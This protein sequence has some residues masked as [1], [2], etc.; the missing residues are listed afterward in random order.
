MQLIPIRE[1]LEDNED[2]IK[3]PLCQETV[4]MTTDFYKKVG[5]VEPWIGYYAEENRDLVGSAGIQVNI[6]QLAYTKKYRIRNLW[7]K[8]DLGIFE[9]NFSISIAAHGAGMFKLVPVE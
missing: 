7:A 5:F 8:K 6:N 2:F 4:H 9:T 3:D 1:R